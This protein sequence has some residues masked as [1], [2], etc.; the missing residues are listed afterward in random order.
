MQSSRVIGSIYSYDGLYY[1]HVLSNVFA[2]ARL[3]IG[4]S[5]PDIATLENVG[6]S[7]LSNTP[8]VATFSKNFK[9]LEVSNDTVTSN[10]V[11]TPDAV[12]TPA[13]VQ[14]DPAALLVQFTAMMASIMPMSSNV[15]PSQLSGVAQ[16]S[17]YGQCQERG[18]G[19]PATGV[20]NPD[21]GESTRGRGLPSSQC[22]DGNALTAADVTTRKGDSSRVTS[23]RYASDR[24][25]LPNG[26]DGPRTKGDSESGKSRE[27]DDS[28]RRGTFSADPP[29]VLSTAVFSQ[30]TGHQSVVCGGNPNPDLIRQERSQYCNRSRSGS[31][32]R[33]HRSPVKSNQTTSTG[34]GRTSPVSDNRTSPSG[35]RSQGSNRRSTV[36]VPKVA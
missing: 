36:R 6:N 19:H 10:S 26:S 35:Q 11:Y 4:V 29:R 16:V 21:E 9:N 28:E 3:E 18:Y 7:Q 15:L 27:R 2:Y 13:P 22:L 20:G 32:D 1:A 14:C 5:T 12:A 24:Q 34:Y 30:I 33:S 17:S 25:P 31:R 8:E 23:L